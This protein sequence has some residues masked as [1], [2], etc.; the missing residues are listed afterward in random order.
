MSGIGTGMGSQEDRGVG[1][2]C[3]EARCQLEGSI[4]GGGQRLQGGGSGNG[5][6]K[7][8][9]EVRELRD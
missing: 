7:D 9:A 4:G 6:S 1:A 5:D 3:R 2:R 8:T